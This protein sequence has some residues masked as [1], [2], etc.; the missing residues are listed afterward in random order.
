MKYVLCFLFSAAAW[1]AS[2]C[3]TAGPGCTEFVKV[4]GGPSRSLIYRTYSL[5]TR[6]EQV[7]RGLVVVHG[8]GRDADNYF[9]SALAAG[10][11]AGALEDTVI[12]VPRIASSAAGCG[13]T[14][15]P[16][17]I[18]WPCDTWRS[19]GAGLTNDKVTSYDFMDEILR[20]LA[21]RNV[22]PNMKVIVVTGH[23]AGGQYAGRYAMANKVH[24][25]LGV[26]VRYV[27]ANPSSYAWLDAARP[28]PDGRGFRRFSDARN[29]TTYD[30]WPYGLENRSGYAAS[31]TDEQLRNQLISR[32]V[33]YLL[34]ELDILPLAGFDSSCPAMAQ[35]PTRLARGQAFG[36]LVN[37]KYGA[38]HIVTVVPL[39]GHNARCM[40]TAETTLPILF[41]KQ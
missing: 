12:V 31:E 36:R 4:G 22:F 37:E 10:F 7:T 24:E 2:P 9:R 8:M 28:A 14:L 33:T 3:T 39:C 1:A 5:E 16:D 29:C 27:V 32:P 6:N 13:D 19:G 30:K 25:T 17:E 35:G 34:G 18:G 21:D 40:Y 20:K 41:P 23:S 38:R 15:A 26:P 11:L